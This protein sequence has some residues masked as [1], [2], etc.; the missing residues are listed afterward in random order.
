MKLTLTR[1]YLPNATRGELEAGDLKLATIERPWVENPDGPGGVLRV[2]CIPEGVY[3][4]LPHNSL[5]FPGTY[6]LENPALCVY[7]DA[8]PAGQGWGRTAILIH[9]GNVV[10][11]VIGCIAVGRKPGILY[12]Q[13]AV[14]RSLD[15]MSLLREKLGRTDEHELTIISRPASAAEE[16]A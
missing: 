1:E 13:P 5:R 12:G 6:V 16:V 3:R 4:V 14:L 7:C 10:R 9:S 11:D 8:R 15:A 2:S